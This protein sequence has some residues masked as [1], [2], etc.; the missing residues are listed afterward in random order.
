MA[1]EQKRQNFLR[2]E[3]EWIHAGAQARSTKQKSRIEHFEKIAAM[4]VQQEHGAY[5]YNERKRK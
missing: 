3:I 1:S 5:A 2:K 4:E